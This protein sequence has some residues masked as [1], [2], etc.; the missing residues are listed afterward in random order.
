[1]KY[2]ANLVSRVR[3]ASATDSESGLS[4]QSATPAAALRAV[5]GSPSGLYQTRRGSFMILVV[6][7]LAL[8]AVITLLYVG[9][10]RADRSGAA[11]SVRGDRTAIV[12]EVF[13][14]YAAQVI[15]N[16]TV[17][18]YEVPK[19]PYNVNV[20]DANREFF[21]KSWD[22]PDTNWQMNTYETDSDS[23]FYFK[24][25]GHLSG[26]TPFLAASTPTYLNSAGNPIP[27]PAEI[28]KQ[29]NDWSHISNFAP[30][31]AFV[32]LYNLRSNVGDPN[33]G[34]D[35]NP[36]TM[37]RFVGLLDSSRRYTN[38][39]EFGGNVTL[40]GGLPSKP[41]EIDS[42]QA[43][44]FQE[45]K[46]GNFST[47]GVDDS[48]FMPYSF[49]DTDG[50]GKYDSRWFELREWRD[51]A[52]QTF[53]SILPQ[54]ANYR[55][56]F[57]ARCV[58]LSGMV[59]V[60]TARDFF[61]INSA[62]T[63]LPTEKL[64]VG[65]SPGEVDLLRLLSLQPASEIYG[66]SYD[67]LNQ[68]VLQGTVFVPGVNAENYALGGAAGLYNEELAYNIARRSYSWLQQ[69]LSHV[70]VRNAEQIGS[71]L[72]LFPT[73]TERLVNYFA[74][75]GRR[76]GV[77]TSSTG[78]GA[79]TLFSVADQ[80]ELLTYWSINDPAVRSRLEA[81]IGA[82]NNA[83][84]DSGE[85]AVS[86]H[87]SPLRDNRSLAIERD[88]VS[89]TFGNQT[90]A[91]EKARL[92]AEI[93][94]R[95][96]ITTVSNAREIQSTPVVRLSTSTSADSLAAPETTSLGATSF[97]RDLTGLLEKSTSVMGLVSGPALNDIF[98]GYADGLMPAISSPAIRRLTWRDPSVP[99]AQR[100]ATRTR[101]YGYNWYNGPELP[102]LYSAFLSVN[103]ADSYDEDH[104][105]RCVTVLFNNAFR[106]E[107]KQDYASPGATQPGDEPLIGNRIAKPLLVDQTDGQL[108]YPWSHWTE[109]AQFDL[110]QG[111][112]A[113]Q[114][115]ADNTS[116]DQTRAPAL[117]V[118]G[119]EATPFI[120]QVGAITVY[121]DAPIGSGGDDDT[122]GD[123]N[124]DLVPD[125][126]VTI[127]GDLNGTNSDL[128]M[129]VVAFQLSNPFDV[130]IVLSTAGGA[131]GL[132]STSNAF[133]PS[134]PPIDG[135]NSFYYLEY[136]GRF[137]KLAGM[138]YE[139][140]GLTD[141]DNANGRLVP[142]K[143][144]PKSSIVVYILDR[145]KK[146]ILEKWNDLDAGTPLTSTKLEGWFA[147]QFGTKPVR[148][149]GSPVEI[150]EFKPVEFDNNIG[151]G[152]GAIVRNSWQD[153]LNVASGVDHNTALLWRSVRAP[154][155]AGNAQPNHESSFWD[156]ASQVFQR[157]SRLND[158]LVD[159][160]TSQK[161][162]DHRLADG[163]KE[164]EE[165]W[166]GAEIP[167][168]IEGSNYN[169]GL[170]IAYF[171]YSRRP[172]SP[173]N[174][175]LDVAAIP[176]WCI[177]PKN[178]ITGWSR[179]ELD[180][181]IDVSA[182][183][184][185][186]QFQS[187]HSAY[188]FSA[189]RTETE[190]I[191]AG[192]KTILDEIQIDATLR[193][194]QAIGSAKVAGID[195]PFE[196]ATDEFY[197]NNKKFSNPPDA[198]GAAA[199]QKAM[200]LGDLFLPMCIGSFEVPLYYVGGTATELSQVYLSGGVQP[201]GYLANMRYRWCTLSEALAVAI[202][203][204]ELS[205]TSA[206]P[207]AA[208]VSTNLV[209][210][211]YTDLRPT[212]PSP[213]V[214]TRRVHDRG[215]LVLDDFVPF[216]DTNVGIAPTGTTFARF[217]R[218]SDYTVGL[219]I[220]SALAVVD[221]FTLATS[222]LTDSTHGKVG[223]INLN[224]ADRQVMSCVPM[225]APIKD[226]IPGVTTNP[227][228]WA[229]S[230]VD[231]RSDLAA[232]LLAYREKSTVHVRTTAQT[233][234]PADDRIFENSAAGADLSDLGVSDG[235]GIATGIAAIHEQPGLRSVGELLSVRNRVTGVDVLP[236][237]DRSNI[238]FLGVGATAATA[239]TV[240]SSRLGVDTILHNDGSGW[241][242]DS[243]VGEYDQKLAIAN[244]AFTA[245]TVRSDTFA[246]Y[247]TVQGYQKADVENLL[248]T[249]P[250]VPSIKRRFLMIVDRSNVVKVGDK[251]RIL[252]FKELPN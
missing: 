8:L 115:L 237:N 213:P 48:D 2:S 78:Y 66:T 167:D 83:D 155:I 34:F 178:E 19:P 80:V 172:D 74:S 26:S 16:S 31:G 148:A 249:D 72:N 14:D 208:D 184:K 119:L 214:P 89:P 243:L 166:A 140:A 139:N 54:D 123:A 204:E 152:G 226:T 96:R 137:Y 245:S 106:D 65:V 46:L 21:R 47:T 92:Q 238:D 73:P 228:W 181:A 109:Q 222:T 132:V 145:S 163:N 188:S 177:Q 1:M 233:G 235:R 157:N 5:A 141:Y 144:A 117:N 150:P 129:R 180:D 62:T 49:A 11:A 162:L 192:D 185:V 7:T 234:T 131:S 114:R 110:N 57:A 41:A 52:V 50:D 200:R 236:F 212:L 189:W 86:P 218:A 55:W 142:L 246:V 70:T 69:S 77:G 240:D 102:L 43:L 6:G 91:Q 124:G 12:P 25:S 159:R 231:Q 29:H 217:D 248:A 75:T 84:L 93:D 81:V 82:R 95:H 198:T 127:N 171:A 186:V 9:I 59:N 35:A 33:A 174:T 153:P 44:L 206:E 135:E 195:K 149:I 122:A 120:T 38:T 244:G 104:T 170:T 160:Y 130:E 216:H 156:Q 111:L 252:A 32:N 239:P 71:N 108:A 154:V 64:P 225:L 24:P 175:A 168:A 118:Y 143:I 20:A 207:L 27:I 107:L 251:P 215:H 13:K 190:A 165:A 147:S 53:T 223:L 105:P 176:A 61:N 100:A 112:R 136:A 173:A 87:R 169:S 67:Q 37:R 133:D 63:L 230:E 22:Y 39:R 211:F 23:R 196:Q 85:Q 58:D 229:G 227:W 221:Q 98:T 161:E 194:T 28:Y 187:F 128:V 219:G 113:T 138:V 15:A 30:D 45:T 4:M 99:G 232:T 250:M 76:D 202:G 203:Y 10:G 18:L 242:K 158:Q 3:S 205:P 201:P 90:Q 209:W 220:P 116:F 210:R 146:D 51:Q 60:N 68:L 94:A 183:P 17:S 179:F 193:H 40:I 126:G 247:F 134:Y 103:L 79:A 56:F 101:F 182:D 191:A 125:D 36:A 241:V 151:R 224:T 197:L 42:R 164:V 199:G 121:A 88:F 97:K